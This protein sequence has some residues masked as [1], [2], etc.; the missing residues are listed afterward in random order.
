MTGN[1]IAPCVYDHGSKMQPTFVFGAEDDSCCW[2]VP[3][4]AAV[5]GA[6]AAGGHRLLVQ[7]QGQQGVPLQ[8]RDL[9]SDR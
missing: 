8:A 1:L 7:Q 2:L 4:L 5:A 6:G 3:G 9:S